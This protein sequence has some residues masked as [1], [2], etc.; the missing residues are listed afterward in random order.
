VPR[1][2]VIAIPTLVLLATGC[3]N[4]STSPSS[5]ATVTLAVANETFRVA[6][7]TPQQVAAARSAQKGGPSD[8]EREGTSFGGGRYCP[9]SATVVRVEE[10]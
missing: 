9:W 6:L 3:G 8:V 4:E 5:A 10:G 2:L 1:R 7:T